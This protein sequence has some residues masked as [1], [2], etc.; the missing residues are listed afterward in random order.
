[1]YCPSAEN[2][3]DL[4]TRGMNVNTLIEKST[5]WLQ[6]PQW[7]SDEEKWPKKETL[8]Q[9]MREISELYI[10]HQKVKEESKQEHDLLKSLGLEKHSNLGSLIRVLVF[11]L[12]FVDKCRKRH[13]PISKVVITKE[14]NRE[15]LLLQNLQEN[16]FKI[17]KELLTTKKKL[18]SKLPA[19]IEQLGLFLD[20]SD[21]LIKCCGRIEYSKLSNLQHLTSKMTF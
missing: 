20:T 14:I 18:T 8:Q 15:T 4:I 19:I 11:V 13:S 17:V 3:A 12:R 6:E 2:P 10:Q 16:H 5:Y 1:M 21:L 7:P 9:P